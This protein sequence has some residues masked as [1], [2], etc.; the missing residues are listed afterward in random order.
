MTS[1]Q[2][3]ETSVTNNIPVPALRHVTIFV[4]YNVRWRE[5]KPF[6]LQFWI[7]PFLVKIKEERKLTQKQAIVG[8]NT[9]E[10]SE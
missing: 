3:V 7:S 1:T 5:I 10:L 9:A 6:D 4:G 2:V 8:K